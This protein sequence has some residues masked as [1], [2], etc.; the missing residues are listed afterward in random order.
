[1]KKDIYVR[2]L[3]VSI[4]EEEMAERKDKVAKLVIDRFGQ[5]QIQ[6]DA[7]KIIT[8]LKEEERANA[9]ILYH[10]TESLEVECEWEFHPDE[11]FKKGGFK[12]NVPFDDFDKREKW[13]ESGK[14]TKVLIRN[15][16]G[17]IVEE[18]PMEAEDFQS[19]LPLEEDSEKAKSNKKSQV[20]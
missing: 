6:E 3:P 8:Q 13:E 12:G 5:E 9:A 17:E 7:K 11:K 1:M 19:K 2:W 10:G 14:G 18:E 15:D 16:T 4:S 20:A